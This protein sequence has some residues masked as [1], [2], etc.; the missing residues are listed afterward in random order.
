MLSHF[1]KVKKYEL[2]SKPTQ[3]CRNRSGNL[4]N[5]KISLFYM[6]AMPNFFFQL[7]KNIFLKI[8]KKNLGFFPKIRKNQKNPWKINIDFSDIFYFPGFFGNFSRFFFDLQKNFFLELKKK[9]EHSFHVEKWDL[10]IYEVSR[11]IPAALQGFWVR[12][13]LKCMITTLLKTLT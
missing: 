11:A 7:Q 5:R 8:E 3:E 9:V 1:I 12:Q 2:V 10:S 6:E 4:I 13:S